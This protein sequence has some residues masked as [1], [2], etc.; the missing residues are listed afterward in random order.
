MNTIAKYPAVTMHKDHLGIFFNAD[1]CGE[2]RFATAIQAQH[3]YVQARTKREEN[4]QQIAACE[5]NRV[6]IDVAGGCA[7]LFE[8]GELIEVVKIHDLRHARQI[9][10]E[11]MD[12]AQSTN[13]VWLSK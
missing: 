3:A 5:P 8:S 2:R 6:E 1:L 11:L 10:H 4:E 7:Q 12:R 9:V 13:V